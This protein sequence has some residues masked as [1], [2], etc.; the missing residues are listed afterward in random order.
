MLS[1]IPPS[2]GMGGALPRELAKSFVLR[3]ESI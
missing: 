3:L 2:M 1:R